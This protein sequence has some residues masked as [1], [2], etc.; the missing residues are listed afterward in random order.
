M[1]WANKDEQIKSIENAITKKINLFD[2]YKSELQKGNIQY[3]SFFLT[4]YY[5]GFPID[6]H[7]VDLDYVYETLKQNIKDFKFDK[8]AIY[9][10]NMIMVIDNEGYEII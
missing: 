8:V 3:D 5:K 7:N 6:F 4:I 1:Y 10:W 2:T 9:L